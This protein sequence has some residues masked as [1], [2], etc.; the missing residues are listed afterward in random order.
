MKDYMKESFEPGLKP[1][2]KLILDLVKKADKECGEMFEE[3][4][5]PTFTSSWVLTW[6]SHNLK[7]FEDI[8][9]VF[10]VCLTQH[11]IFPVYLSAAAIVSNKE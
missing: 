6:Y 10:D 7:N 1:A 5:I 9:R 2:L 4:E 11:P 8:T 3:M